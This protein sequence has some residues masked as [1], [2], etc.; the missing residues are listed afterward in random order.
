METYSPPYDS[1]N[2]KIDL[3]TQEYRKFLI[4]NKETI[5]S[6][7]ILFNAIVTSL[8][9]LYPNYCVKNHVRKF[10]RALPSKW[11]A[12]VTE[13]KEAKDLATLPLDELFKNLKAEAFNLMARN[14]C[15]FFH[16]GNRFGN[17]ANRFERGR[18]NSF[19]NK[20]GESSRKKEVCYNCGVEGHFPSECTKPKENKALGEKLRVIVKMTMNLRRMQHVSRKLTLK[21][22]GVVWNKE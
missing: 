11:R 1:T 18:K 20:G 6:G 3:L 12:N 2:C 15:K 13:I 19:E 4:S 17:D 9:S 22:K 5:D 7:F 14:F 8:T 21:R 10:L 16:K